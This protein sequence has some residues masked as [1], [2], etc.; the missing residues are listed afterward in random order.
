MRQ[1]LWLVTPMMLV[2]CARAEAPVPV[3]HVRQRTASIRGQDPTRGRLFVTFRQ[4]AGSGDRQLARLPSSYASASVTLSNQAS[5]LANPLTRTLSLAAPASQS[6]AVF[7]RLRPGSGYALD[8]NLFDGAQS[9]ATG[10]RTALTL[11]S[12]INPVTVVMSE[13]GEI[14]I[15]T[16]HNGNTVGSVASWII[17]KGD[18]VTFDTGFGPDELPRYQASN[19]GRNLTMRVYLGDGQ[20]D[21]LLDPPAVD[22]LLATASAPF[23]TFTWNTGSPGASF[24]PANLTTTATQ[25]SRLKFQL[26]D[27]LGAIVG[28]SILAPLSV[29]AAAAI[30]LELQ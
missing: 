29:V 14:A 17:A 1:F 16:S 28:E 21:D 5:L 24:D 19:P 22:T 30:D 25:A 4:D 3:D 13:T 9:V 15:A 8:V 6:T 12:G 26:V 11:S 20:S 23:D 2:A 27:D 7:G 18:T 10:K